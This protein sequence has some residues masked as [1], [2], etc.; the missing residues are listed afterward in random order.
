MKSL[1]T[2]WEYVFIALGILMIPMLGVGLFILAGVA[3]R[4]GTR[5]ERV[6]EQQEEQRIGED[7][8]EEKI[9]IGMDSKQEETYKCDEYAPEVVEDGR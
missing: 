7:I 8:G 6:A 4:I 9:P 3:W 1:I 5:M 2:N